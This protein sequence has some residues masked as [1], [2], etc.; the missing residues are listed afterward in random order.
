M[1]AKVNKEL[2]EAVLTC[3][4]TA[5][6]TDYDARSALGMVRGWIEDRDPK[7]I[8]RNDFTKEMKGLYSKRDDLVAALVEILTPANKGEAAEAIARARAWL[9]KPYLDKTMMGIR[10][11]PGRDLT[12]LKDRKK[13]E[14]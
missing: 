11:R 13:A 5:G 12:K 10:S 3:V 14:K 8:A 9:N 7:K 2:N 4:Q 6:L 1:P